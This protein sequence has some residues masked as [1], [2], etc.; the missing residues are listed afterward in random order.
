[1]DS[2]DS[3][4]GLEV[5]LDLAL[6]FLEIR[7]GGSGGDSVDSCCS[8]AAERVTLDDMSVGSGGE[9]LQKRRW[10]EMQQQQIM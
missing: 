10:H 3:W 4:V 8:R 5:G 7:A 6:R 2:G 9:R 1:M